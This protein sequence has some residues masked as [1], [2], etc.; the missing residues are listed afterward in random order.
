[1]LLCLWRPGASADSKLSVSV[2]MGVLKALLRSDS[3]IPHC[4]ASSFP[5]PG[6]SFMVAELPLY[7]DLDVHVCE[8]FGFVGIDKPNATTLQYDTSQ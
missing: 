4:F 3:F 8:G 1:M 7:M 5:P 2:H 6:T